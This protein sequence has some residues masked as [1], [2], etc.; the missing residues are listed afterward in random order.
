MSLEIVYVSSLEKVRR[1]D[2]YKNLV[3]DGEPPREPSAHPMLLRGEVFSFQHVLHSDHHAEVHVQVLPPWNEFVKVYAVQ[4]APVD[5]PVYTDQGDDD[6]LLREPG[7][8]PDILQPL[9]AQ[10]HF[11]R[12]NH[13]AAL[14][15]RL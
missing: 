11:L 13:S 7:L 1:P 15:F 14:W 4:N 10:H 2:L 3:L 8:M 9:E 5:L 12:L 6:Y